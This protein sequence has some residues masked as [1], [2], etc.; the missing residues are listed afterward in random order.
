[1]LFT[2]FILI[3]LWIAGSSIGLST[4]VAALIGLSGL[5]LSGVLKWKDIIEEKSAWDTFFWF[6]ALVT[7]AGFLNK[8]GL[9]TWF[10][11]FVVTHV[12]GYSWPMGFVILSILYYYSHYFFASN[13]AHIGAMYAPFVLVAIALGVPKELA[14]LSFAFFSSLF[15]G[16]TH[17]GCGPAP[18]MF[19]S[20]YV[21]IGSWWKIGFMASVVNIFIWLVFGGLWWKVLGLW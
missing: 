21:S 9:T 7:M 4:T 19:G 8:L 5:I 6:A 20:G 15:G 10:S 14:A 12:E 2:F 11:S 13:L 17:Y 1:M 3:T 18:I 16:L